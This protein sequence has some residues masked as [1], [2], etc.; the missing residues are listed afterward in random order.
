METANIFM[1]WRDI[2]RQTVRAPAVRI[3]PFQQGLGPPPVADIGM[4]FE[5]Y[6]NGLD[7]CFAQS[8]LRETTIRFFL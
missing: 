7:F 6:L 2:A 8:D 5:F 3:L 1:T 4:Y